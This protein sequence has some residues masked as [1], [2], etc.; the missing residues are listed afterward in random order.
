MPHTLSNKRQTIRQVMS[1]R[2]SEYI[3]MSDSMPEYMSDKMSEYVSVSNKMSNG[4]SCRNIYYGGGSQQFC[5]RVSL[6]GATNLHAHTHTYMIYDIYI[7]STATSGNN[8]APC[9]SNSGSNPFQPVPTNYSQHCC[10]TFGGRYSSFTSM[11]SPGIP[12]GSLWL[13]GQSTHGENTWDFFCSR[14]WPSRPI[15]MRRINK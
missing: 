1:G 9:F 5:L 6:W 13:P 8:N 3:C 12:N 4:M 7:Y 14:K 11:S 2:V 15:E 10:G